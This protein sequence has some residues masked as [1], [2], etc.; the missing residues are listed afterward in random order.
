MTIDGNHDYNGKLWN[1]FEIC[2]LKGNGLFKIKFQGNFAIL[3]DTLI[4]IDYLQ[5]DKLFLFHLKKN[6]IQKLS[7][8]FSGWSP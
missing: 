6:I 1:L 3:I 7:S 2:D 5:E 8:H 4:L